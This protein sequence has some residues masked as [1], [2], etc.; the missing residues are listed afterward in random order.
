MMDFF[1][2]LVILAVIAVEVLIG[3]AVVIWAVNTVFG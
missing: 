2:G 3:L 1:C